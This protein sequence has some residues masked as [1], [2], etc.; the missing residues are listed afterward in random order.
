MEDAIQRAIEF[1]ARKLLRREEKKRF[2]KKKY[3]RR[4][5]LRTGTE[6]NQGHHRWPGV[7]AVSPHFDPRY[8]ISHAKYLARVLWLK[9]RQRSYEPAAAVRYKI[10]KETGGFREIMVFSIPDAAIANLFYRKLRDKNRNLFSPFSYAYMRERGLFDAVIQL[11]S[12]LT[13]GKK[14]IIQFDFAK[15]FDSIDHKYLEHLFGK[16]PFN[17]SDTEKYLLR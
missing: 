1:Q 2:A 14:Y 11:K 15:Y 8:C 13:P 16:L 12:Y 3:Q 5:K 17:I 7:W 4:F 9:I 6:P 10:A